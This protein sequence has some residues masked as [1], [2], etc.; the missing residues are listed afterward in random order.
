MAYFNPAGERARRGVEALRAG[1]MPTPDELYEQMLRQQ[2]AGLKA[3]AGGNEV[4]LS[5]ASRGID[6]L[7]AEAARLRDVQLENYLQGN[8]SYPVNDAT[9]WMTWQ[10]GRTAA[11]DFNRLTEGEAPQG[12]SIVGHAPQYGQTAATEE[13]DMAG[14]GLASLSQY[15]T[16]GTY[17][18]EQ[19][20]RRKADAE[21]AEAES[22]AQI[23]GG[24]TPRGLAEA[25]ERELLESIANLRTGKT[26]FVMGQTA[27]I[28]NQ[29]A[30]EKA[31]TQDAIARASASSQGATY[32]DQNVAAQ[33]EAETRRQLELTRAQKVEPAAVTGG[34]RVAAEQAKQAGQLGTQESR[35]MA[36]ILVS[37]LN[38]FTRAATADQISDEERARSTEAANVI[39]QIMDSMG[40]QVQTIGPVR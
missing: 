12:M 39:K 4:A 2:T 21:A 36:N 17:W 24:A 38:N 14:Q 35:N 25:R 31:A 11:S 29:L 9:N 20:R 28:E 19:A 13:K 18:D 5:S 32:F 34:W 7:K 40:I 26:G 10:K 27:G 22:R 23:M 15:A 1:P 33:R 37:L 6:A 30:G 16:G 3:K 8:R